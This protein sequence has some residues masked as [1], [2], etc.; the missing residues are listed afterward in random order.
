M[1]EPISHERCSELLADHAAGRL[2]AADAAR[3]DA[4]LAACA[5]CTAELRAVMALRAPVEDRPL[6]ELERARLRSGIRRQVAAQPTP[7]SKPSRRWATAASALGAAALLAIGGFAVV[8]LSSGGDDSETAAGGSDDSGQG[9]GTDTAE[10]GGGARLDAAAPEAPPRPTFDQD[11]GPLSSGKLDELG[12]KNRALA[13]FARAY[14]ADDASRLADRYV[15]E[16]ANQAG[17][18]NERDLIRNCAASVYSAQPY[19]ALLAYGAR[20]RLQGREALVLGFAW[21]DED[22]GVLD[23]FMLWTWPQDSCD[24]PIDYRSGKIGSRK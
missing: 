24:Q 20:G 7:A 8:S 10:S 23:Q 13:G 15:D 19:P 3:V 11:V 6:T 4:H 5:E 9:G 16:L 1:T 14:S 22:A 17:D 12:R 18:P 2:D 21:T